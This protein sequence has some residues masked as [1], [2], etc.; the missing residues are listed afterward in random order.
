MLRRYIVLPA[1]L[2]AL[3]VGD[4]SA[5]TCTVVGPRGVDFRSHPDFNNSIVWCSFAKGRIFAHAYPLNEAFVSVN[6]PRREYP[7]E[8]YHERNVEVVVGYVAKKD[9]NYDWQLK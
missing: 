6:I 5:M 8:C 7:V 4:A 3:G 2:L 9:P 1:I